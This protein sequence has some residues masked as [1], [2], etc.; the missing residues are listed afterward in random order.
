MDEAMHPYRQ[1]EDT[2]PHD[3]GDGIDSEECAVLAVLGI[4]GGIGIL[5]GVFYPRPLE[6]SLGVLFGTFA[7]RM[8]WLER[9]RRRSQ[10]LRGRR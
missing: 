2:R 6:L 8:L 3:R 4:V 5:I 7:L 9:M 10:D 1:S